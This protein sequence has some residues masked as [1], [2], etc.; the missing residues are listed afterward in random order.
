MTLQEALED[1]RTRLDVFEAAEWLNVRIRAGRV[2]LLCNGI[3]VAPHFFSTHLVIA[4]KHTPHGVPFLE[5]AVLRAIEP[6]P[7]VWSLHPESFRAAYAERATNRGGAPRK[8]DREVI[9]GEAWVY[10]AVY[11]LPD[12]LTG[13]GG[14][15]EK[16]EVILGARCPERTQLQTILSPYFDRI[17]EGRESQGSTKL[18]LEHDKQSH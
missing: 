1:F 11:G 5:V 18:L 9:L 6:G 16:L 8:Y 17:K 7:R 15:L 14:L 13:E 12:T 2:Y 3:A 4:G 10:S